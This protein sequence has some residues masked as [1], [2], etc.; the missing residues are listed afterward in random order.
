MDTTGMP[1]DVLVVEDNFIIGLDT[2]MILRDLGVVSVRLAADASAA[3]RAIDAQSPDFA[4][5]DVDLGNSSG[6]DVA[7]VL[8]QRGVPFAFVTGYA[9]LQ[10]PPPQLRGAPMIGKPYSIDSLREL[11]ERA[12][13]RT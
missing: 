4:L 12:Q 11:L 2:E 7:I 13:P 6:Y 3:L 5:I 1:C 9:Q 8:A 10:S